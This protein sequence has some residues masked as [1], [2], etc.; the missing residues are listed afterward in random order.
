MVQQREIETTVRSVIMRARFGLFFRFKAQF[1]K[2]KVFSKFRYTGQ[3]C[4][5][6]MDWRCADN[7]H[8]TFIFLL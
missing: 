3:L 1:L 7:V 8:F 4:G 6:W 2:F 5:K